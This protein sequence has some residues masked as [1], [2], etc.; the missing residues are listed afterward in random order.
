[1]FPDR[2]YIQ[3]ARAHISLQLRDYYTAWAAWS[4][5]LENN[6]LADSY[7]LTST[8]NEMMN[9]SKYRNQLEDLHVPKPSLKFFNHFDVNIKIY[10]KTPDVLRHLQCEDLETYFNNYSELLVFTDVASWDRKRLGTRLDRIGVFGRE[11]WPML[12]P[13]LQNIFKELVISVIRSK[14]QEVIHQTHEAPWPNTTYTFS[15][16]VES[17]SLQA[18]ANS[19]ELRSVVDCFLWLDAVTGVPDKASLK[20]V[21]YRLSDD[22]P[23]LRKFRSRRMNR[24]HDPDSYGHDAF[25]LYPSDDQPYEVKASRLSPHLEKS[26]A[27][28]DLDSD[29]DKYHRYSSVP[30][31]PPLWDK[32]EQQEEKLWNQPLQYLENF[33]PGPTNISGYRDSE[34]HEE[35]DI[36]FNPLPDKEKHHEDMLSTSQKG[37]ISIKS[38]A[39]S[40]LLPSRTPFKFAATIRRVVTNYHWGFQYAESSSCWVE[41]VQKAYVASYTHLFR[42]PFR[43]QIS[44]VGYGLRTNFEV[45]LAITGVD[46]HIIFEE[47]LVLFGF[48][49]ALIP[50]KLLNKSQKVVQWH[51][52]VAK[53]EDQRFRSLKYRTD[54]WAEI[55]GMQ[56][57]LNMPIESLNGVAYIGWCRRASVKL[58][59]DESN[60]LKL[61]GLPKSDVKW[62]LKEKSYGIAPQIGVFNVGALQLNISRVYERVVPFFRFVSANLSL[63]VDMLRECSLIVYDNGRKTAWLCPLLNFIMFLFH[64]YLSRHNYKAPQYDGDAEEYLKQLNFEENF[65]TLGQNESLTY[66]ELLMSLIDRYDAAYGSI[67]HLPRENRL[68]GF[69]I[70]D[71]ID[72]GKA[73][74]T[75]LMA[76]DGINCWHRF[77]HNIDIVFGKDLGDV[78][79]PVSP[80]L[81]GDSFKM[82]LCSDVLPS[83]YNI[84]VCPT[85][86][87]RKKLERFGC[88]FEG[89]Y[90]VRKGSG[91]FKWNLSGSPFECSE[92]MEGRTCKGDPDLCWR[93]RLQRFEPS[94]TSTG[95]IISPFRLS[96][97]QNVKMDPISTVLSGIFVGPLTTDDGFGAICFGSTRST[98][99]EMSVLPILIYWLTIIVE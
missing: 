43:N 71:L 95:F 70:L 62:Q 32:R 49:T 35:F 89:D 27:H 80:I 51:L 82:E 34:R 79:I 59:S 28:T 58:V 26:D 14:D 67:D 98:S 76:N 50:I 92:K 85:H 93:N 94:K 86:L 2:I 15:A 81:P 30:F 60:I 8:L 9:S 39:Q 48:K 24:I 17:I 13:W 47:G 38:Q 6:R 97:S 44:H 91:S 72:G 41:L 75:S 5:I 52:L 16:A 99:H 65:S 73:E 25:S 20:K 31:L 77:A 12:G 4:Q 55:R 53:T 10:W 88:L 36:L 74:V 78:I 11:Q 40:V 69:E 19:R 96:H 87:L 33:Y 66:G 57:V 68:I 90:V 63:R 84:L 1:M 7:G 18:V 37:S 3:L 64:A 29:S 61:S 56:R 42:L 45:M 46:Q 22:L 21:E 83:G 54:I 23:L